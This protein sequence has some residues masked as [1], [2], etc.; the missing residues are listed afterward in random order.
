MAEMA[1]A[2]GL[3]ALPLIFFLTI[4]SSGYFSFDNVSLTTFLL[5]RFLFFGLVFL[6]FYPPSFDYFSLL[7]PPSFDYFFMLVSPFLSV[8]FFPTGVGLL[9]YFFCNT[10]L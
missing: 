1:G 2:F 9:Q 4:F 3:L 8:G 6:F 7:L 5:F 10:F